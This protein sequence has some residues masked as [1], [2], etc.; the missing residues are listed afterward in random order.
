MA[1]NTKRW[2]V[3]RVVGGKE[4]KIKEYIE[5]EIANLGLTDFVSQVLIPTEKAFQIRNG[6]KIAVER[7]ILPGYVMVE[8]NLVGEIPHILRG[9]TNVMGFLGDTKGG[10]PVPMRQREVDRILGKVDELA[11]KAEE[12]AI[13][14]EVGDSVKVVDGPFSDFTGVVEEVNKERK[15][16]KVIVKIFGRRTPL[17]LSYVQVEK[18]KE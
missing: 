13:P 2:Y 6:K 10:D 12:L 4:R 7:N 16:L 17:E 3:L 1:D 15:K 14:Y 18:E 9:M 8:A 11:D 5:K